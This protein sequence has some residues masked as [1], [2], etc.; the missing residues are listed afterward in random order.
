MPGGGTFGTVAQD[1]PADLSAYL[2]H[3]LPA[4]LPRYAAPSEHENGVAW[5]TGNGDSHP[6]AVLELARCR[7]GWTPRDWYNRLLQ[8]VGRCAD[9]N[10]ERAAELRSAAALMAGRGGDAR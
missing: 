4:A 6:K 1:R 3:T 10:P 5:Y 7:D 8:L 2:G 9:L